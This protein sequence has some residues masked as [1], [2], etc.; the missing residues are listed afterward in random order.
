MLVELT[1]VL[2]LLNILLMMLML[3]WA[4]SLLMERIFLVWNSD[5]KTIELI[6]P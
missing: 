4:E 5:R 1:L 2:L 3:S 6:Q